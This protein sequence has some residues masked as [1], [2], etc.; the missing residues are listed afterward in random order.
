[1]GTSQGSKRVRRWQVAAATL[2]L[3]PALMAATPASAQTPHYDFRETADSTWMTN[4][5][6]TGEPWVRA[7]AQIGDVVYVG[8]GFD[9]IRWTRNG[10]DYAP[11]FLAAFDRATGQPLPGFD[12]VF[13]GGVRALA[14][15]PD[16]STLYAGGSFTSV[17]GESR[18]R[19]V[20]L[21]PATGAVTSTFDVSITTGEVWALAVRSNGDVYVGGSFNRIDGQ[22][23]EKLARLDGVTG[24]LSAWAPTAN[25]GSVRALEIPAAEDRIYAGGGFT[26]I[27]SQSGTSYLVAI[28]LDTGAPIFSFDAGAANT[29]MAVDSAEDHV[30]VA[31]GGEN[32]GSNRGLALAASDG[33]I[34][35]TYQVD[36]DVQVVR[37]VGDRIYFGGHWYNEF[38]NGAFGSLQRLGAVRLDN[39]NVDTSFNPGFG[40]T[41]GV[42]AIFFDGSRL[43]VGGDLTSGGGV[44]FRGFVRFRQTG[45]TN[46]SAPTVPTGV[47]AEPESSTRISLTWNPASDDS[48]AVYYRIRQDGAT[49]FTT[50]DTQYLATGL[51]VASTH[52]YTVEAIDPHGNL[53][54]QSNAAVGTTF[55]YST[56]DFVPEGSTWKYLSDGTNQGTAWRQVGFNDA[57]W[58]SGAAELGFGDGDEATDIGGEGAITYYFRKAFT[59]PTGTTVHTLE[60]DLKRDDG[61]VVYLNGQELTRVNM[62]GGT[63]TSSTVATG[64]VENATDSFEFSPGLIQTGTNVL[65]VEVH[66]RSADSSDV[67]FGARLAG[68]TSH[69]VAVTSPSAGAALTGGVTVNVSAS[70]LEDAAG[71]LD[72]EVSTNGGSTWHDAAWNASAGAYRYAWNTINASDGSHTLV[73]RS[74]D[75][76]GHFETSPP[77]AVTVTNRPTVAVITPTDGAVGGTVVIEIGADDA[78]DPPGSLDVEVSIAGGPWT[79]TTWSAATGTY[80]L[81]W[82]TTTLPDG[83]VTLQA[84]ATDSHGL[85]AL[86][87]IV[88]TSVINSDAVPDVAITSPSG[89]SVSGNVAVSVAATDV[90]D[91]AGALEVAVSTDGGV[92][93]H[94]A[95]WNSSAG[96][97]RY[98]WNTSAIADGTGAILRAR[99]IDSVGHEVLSAPV[100]VTVSDD[101]GTGFLDV[102]AAHLFAGDVTWLAAAGIT[103]G[104]NP[105]DNDEFCPNDPVTRGQMAAFLVRALHLTASDASIDFGDDDGSIFE[106]DIIKL[107][108]AK[109]TLGCNPPTNDRYCPDGVVTR[110]QMAAFLVRALHLTAANGAIDFTDDNGSIFEADIVKLATAGITVG[111]NPPDNDRFCPNQAVTRGQMA[112]FL[113][114]ALG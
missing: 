102:P 106:A 35:R 94:D 31:V 12:P 104:C 79:D 48:G 74:R 110:G 45:D 86:S 10:D 49:V 73:A 4:G 3:V 34:Q 111:C 40:G 52:S 97:Y 87:P 57:S 36:G 58:D 62:P 29:V 16:G 15:S 83:P 82:N 70:D 72:V 32:S 26:S 51:G 30:F 23:R 78:A 47:T 81:S 19:I 61:A 89:G 44:P 2:A 75:S 22:V 77:V 88:T 69:A 27:N 24:A 55:A 37:A 65:A 39:L 38:T 85:E 63:I 17:N 91:A 67:S 1:M 20:A 98:S 92:T 100:S 13:D 43:W 14:V 59:I 8:G 114:R 54:G 76:A 11:G 64:T 6:G 7:F 46:A 9:A 56:T 112:A 25:S 93:W 33:H 50:V 28:D 21:D 105:P 66:Q 18:P 95:T 109:I 99:A 42:W 68:S 5:S 101:G 71:T 96:V 90:E 113:H 60:L 53:S 107:A 80:R 108:T 84:R 41:M 103:R